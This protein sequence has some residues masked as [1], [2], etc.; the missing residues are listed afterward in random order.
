MIRAYRGMLDG[1]AG[2][3]SEALQLY[4]NRDST[5]PLAPLASRLSKSQPFS[6]CLLTARHLTVPVLT[7]RSPLPRNQSE[8]THER[9][10]LVLHW[11]ALTCVN[12]LNILPLLRV[13]SVRRRS[14]RRPVCA[15]A[16]N[17]HAILAAVSH[18]MACQNA[19]NNT[20]AAQESSSLS[21]RHQC[22]VR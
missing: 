17:V 21:A 19:K 11:P 6:S 9:P 12:P 7:V 14:W 20:V 10:G 22:V 3:G 8:I 16:L 2:R 13:R 4:S 1:A 18:R 15:I 5:N